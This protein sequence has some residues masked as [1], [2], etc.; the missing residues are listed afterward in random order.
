MKS[1][2]VVAILV[3][4]LVTFAIADSEQSNNSTQQQ[5][6]QAGNCERAVPLPPW[7][8]SYRGRCWYVCKGWPIRFEFEPEGISCGLVTVNNT[9]RVCK[10]GSCV[11]AESPSGQL[12]QKR[13]IPTQVPAPKQ[14]SGIAKLV[15]TSDNQASNDATSTKPKST[16]TLSGLLSKKH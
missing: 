6:E 16:S 7:A 11:K 5:P 10:R 8:K 4:S 15:A 12:E 13:L 1:S 2:L 9:K 3:G 14:E